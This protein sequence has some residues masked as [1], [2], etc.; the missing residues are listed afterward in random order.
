M[1]QHDERP[2]PSGQSNAAESSPAVESV[3]P[4]SSSFVTDITDELTDHLSLAARDLQLAGHPADEAQKLAHRK[5]G[6]I[7]TIRRRLWWIHQGDQLMLRIAL[8]AALVILVVAVAAIGVG[9]WQMNRTIGE[10]GDTLATMNET[11]RALLESRV[12]EDRPLAIRGRLYL[13]D[14]SR[15]ASYASVDIVPLPEG[16]PVQRLLADEDGRFGTSSLTAGHYAVVAN[17]IP[18]KTGETNGYVPQFFAKQSR[19]ISVYP[20]SKDTTVELDLATV[21]YGQVSIEFANTLPQKFEFEVQREKSRKVAIR[22]VLGVVIPSISKK[23]PIE[24]LVG[25][26]N[27]DWPIIGLNGASESSHKW[28]SSD[29]GVNVPILNS[30][31][32]SS[33]AKPTSQEV[34]VLSGIGNTDVFRAGNYRIAAYVTFSLTVD[35]VS[36]YGLSE[37]VHD[38]NLNVL[39]A[40]SRAEFEVIDARRTHLRATLPTDL[41]KTLQD[42]ITSLFAAPDKYTEVRHKPLPVKLEVVGQTDIVQPEKDRGEGVYAGGYGGRGRGGSGI[43]GDPPSRGAYGAYGGAR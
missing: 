20:W 2:I 38:A 6:D 3:A 19:P 41:Q 43:F 9:G 21:G 33:S 14:K 29:R 28:V 1:A 42:E 22:P 27:F 17:L 34:I 4:S 5:F 26:E 15:P 35:N 36:D 37:L 13:G 12:K 40:E 7:A 31:A 18:R 32:D 25:S 11:Q 23:L 16:K 39:P 30:I 8:A 10:L 24:K